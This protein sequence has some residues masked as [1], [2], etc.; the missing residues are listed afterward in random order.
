MY[1][2]LV[3]AS[4]MSKTACLFGLLLLLL[5][6]LLLLF[7]RLPFRLKQLSLLDGASS[8][9]PLASP[10]VVQLSLLVNARHR[11]HAELAVV[12]QLQYTRNHDNRVRRHSNRDVT[13]GVARNFI[14]GV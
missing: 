1:E 7:L 5:L 14:W 8:L 13:R 11:E 12:Q 3:T 6:R 2:K 9:L 4:F 10:L